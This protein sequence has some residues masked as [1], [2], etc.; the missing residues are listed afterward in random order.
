MGLK[1]LKEAI[2][3]AEDVDLEELPSVCELLPGYKPAEE[4]QIK[5]NIEYRFEWPPNR[6]IHKHCQLLQTKKSMKCNKATHVC[7][8]REMSLFSPKME[9][10]PFNF[11]KYFGFTK[12]HSSPVYP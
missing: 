9:E 5:I 10:H 12:L 6:H 3:V 11:Q 7:E 2:Q 1:E 8:T 4:N